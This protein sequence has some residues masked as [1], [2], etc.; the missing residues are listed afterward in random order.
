MGTLPNPDGTLF[1]WIQKRTRSSNLKE[2]DG[3]CIYFLLSAERRRCQLA[4]VVGCKAVGSTNNIFLFCHGDVYRNTQCTPGLSS[5]STLVCVFSHLLTDYPSISIYLFFP[6]KARR[7]G[8]LKNH[9]TNSSPPTRSIRK[10][11]LSF[12]VLALAGLCA[13][14]QKPEDCKP[15]V[16]LII[17]EGNR[18]KKVTSRVPLN[19]YRLPATTSWWKGVCFFLSFPPFLSFF[20]F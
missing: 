18:K 10:L 12:V 13:A 6:L 8:L 9:S 20:L 16:K 3:P 15:W 1:P 2:E 4:A 19:R 7:E 14:K 11:S 5:L 17:G